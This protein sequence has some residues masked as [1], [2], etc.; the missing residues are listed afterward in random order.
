MGKNIL[1]DLRNI[2]G[3]AKVDEYAYRDPEFQI[4][5][6]PEELSRYVIAINDIIDAIEN[7]NVRA[8]GGS[9]ESYR[10]Q[11]NILTLS[12]FETIDEVRDVIL[13]A[14]YGGGELTLSQV[15]DVTEGFSDEKIRTI[16]NGKKGISFVV[17]KSTNAD[18][19]NLVDRITKYVEEKQ[20]MMP[21]GVELIT[22]NDGSL[23]VRNR[24][25]IVMNNA[26][27]GFFL[28]VGVLIFF[29][30][31]RSSFWIAMSIPAAFSVSL[32]IIPW[33]GVDLNAITLSAMILVL[34][35]L[36]DDSIVVSEN[37]FTHRQTQPP[38]QSAL[39][40]TLEVFTPVIAT[41]LTTM[42]AF[43]PMLVM[44]GIMGRFVY[45]IPITIIAALAGSILD[46]FCILP[47]HLYHSS[48]K[49]DTGLPLRCA[50]T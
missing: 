4:E 24:L 28:V 50:F 12:E 35:M 22:V 36:V 20:A 49:I 11:R 32:I 6:K 13:R 14:A 26:I 2:K 38:Y 23:N 40:G 25:K 47:N 34:G 41:V 15:A 31:A 27:L 3:V 18:I 42:L 19:I 46:C 43:A 21:P 44:S 39:N 45:V 5:I 17:K 30:N 1:R 37:I 29:L 33:F 7:R 8:T 16:F 48:A 9:L 10:T